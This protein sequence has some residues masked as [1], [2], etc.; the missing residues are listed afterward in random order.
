MKIKQK[1]FHVKW[2]MNSMNKLT[3]C[4]MWISCAIVAVTGIVITKD[5]ESA[6]WIMMIPLVGLIFT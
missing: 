1:Q 5:L 2:R 4:I 6:V 3:N